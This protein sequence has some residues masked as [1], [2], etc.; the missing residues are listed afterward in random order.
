MKKPTELSTARQIRSRTTNDDEDDEQTDMY[1]RAREEHARAVEREQRDEIKDEPIV[2]ETSK[3]VSKPVKTRRIN[4]EST[5]VYDDEQIEMGV[6]MNSRKK[7]KEAAAATEKKKSETIDSKENAFDVA[8]PLASE[9]KRQAQETRIERIRRLCEK[10]TI[11]EVLEAA[12]Q[13]YFERQQKRQLYKD[14]LER[15]E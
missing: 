9:K 10:R 5:Q 3:I 7:K 12:Q 2:E 14:Y 15:A 8:M 11:G 1:S 6:G 13:A 4:D